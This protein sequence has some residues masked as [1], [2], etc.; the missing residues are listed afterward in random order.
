MA[1]LESIFLLLAIFPT[2]LAFLFAKY[3]DIIWR[4]KIFR[5][6]RKKDY[7]ILNIF[8]RD[9]KT[10]RSMVVNFE[11]DAVKVGDNIWIIAKSRIYRQH[12]ESVG[13]S[14]KGGKSPV[15]WTEGVPVLYVEMDTVK[16]LAFEGEESTIKSDEVGANL[17]A[18]INNQIMKKK[19]ALPSQDK[20]TKIILIAVILVGAIAYLSFTQQT[21]ILEVCKAAKAAAG[22]VPSEVN[23]GT[24][25]NGTQVIR[26]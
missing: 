21:E 12:N 14:L 7:G 5:R 11:E 2:I 4:A 20:I 17:M 22:T 25:E 23:I 13:F 8:S 18:W 9:G 19:H 24:I 16:P 10:I 1:E 6:L 26:G 15:R 3:Q